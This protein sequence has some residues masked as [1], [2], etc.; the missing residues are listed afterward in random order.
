MHPLTEKIAHTLRELR[1]QRRWSLDAT[2]QKTGVSKA[3]LGQIER[4]ESS[5][6]IATLWKIARGFDV[7]FSSFVEDIT[8]SPEHVMHRISTLQNMHQ[9]D[10]KIQVMPIFPFDAT[11][12]FEV[13][14]IKLLPGCTHLSPAHQQGVVEHII[15][16]N[17]SL[18]ILVEETWHTLKPHEGLRFDASIPHGYRNLCPNAVLFHDMIHYRQTVL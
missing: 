5:P 16:L 10:D 4:M 8:Q 17:G 13:F 14:M 15:P 6:T 18:D 9:H 1:Q 7:S 3:M 12:G 2:A 11:L